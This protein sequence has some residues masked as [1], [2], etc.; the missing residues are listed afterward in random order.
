MST[1]RQAVF[2]SVSRSEKDVLMFAQQSVQ[3]R[4]KGELYVLAT[5]SIL[6]VLTALTASAQQVKPSEIK[7]GKEHRRNRVPVGR[8]QKHRL[9]PAHEVNNL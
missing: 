4:L 2:I 3:F 1:A 7:S 8:L 6:L 5:L 9:T